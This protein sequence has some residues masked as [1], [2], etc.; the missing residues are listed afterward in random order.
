MLPIADVSELV[1][2]FFEAFKALH[3]RSFPGAYYSGAQIINRLDEQNKVFV[4]AKNKTLQGYVY[5]RINS[6]FSEGYIDF[7]GVEQASRRLGVGTKLVS[8]AVQWLFS[9]DDISDV[10]LIVSETNIDAAKL[11]QQLGFEVR[12]KL[13]GYRKKE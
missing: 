11:Y 13:V 7:L 8:A 12:R 5:S 1:P 9:I 4:I 3:D 2:D 10:G 6:S